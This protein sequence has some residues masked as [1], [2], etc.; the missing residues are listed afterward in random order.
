MIPQQKGCVSYMASKDISNDKELLFRNINSSYYNVLTAL[1]NEMI[2]CE[3]TKDKGLTIGE[4]VH[5]ADYIGNSSCGDYFIRSFT[6][7]DPHFELFTSGDEESAKYRTILCDRYPRTTMDT[8]MIRRPL[9]EIELRWLKSIS[10]DPRIKLF[11]D[12]KYGAEDQVDFRCLDGLD[13]VEPLFTEDD[14][15][16]PDRFSNGDNYSDPD[17]ICNFHTILKAVRSASSGDD[18]MCLRL[19][20]TPGREGRPESVLVK[21]VDI[22][23]S[24]KDDRFRLCGFDLNDL[25]HRL[26]F[27]N[28]SRI[29]KC[30]MTS[31]D[32]RKL[33]LTITPPEAFTVE[34]TEEFRRNSY[35]RFMIAFEHYGK[36]RPEIISDTVT[37][38]AMY[39]YQE[40]ANE[41]VS[42][43]LQFGPDVKVI[44]PESF[45]ERIRTKLRNQK[46][47]DARR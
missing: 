33:D 19:I 4:I 30:E 2:H 27:F 44:G 14:I 3:M 13:D 1:I 17:Y 43:L 38:V 40:D 47:L 12:R 5:I 10:M 42:K 39:Y 28:I 32:T 8:H 35:E 22:E 23:Y 16:I 31:I 9:S 37:R 29:E 25:Q 20:Y 36:D 7:D 21:P 41:V 24:E 46:E 11:Q 6:E 15:R 45:V 18:K 26:S 34:I